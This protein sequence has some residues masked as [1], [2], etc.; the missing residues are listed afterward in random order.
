L[1][2]RSITGPW[3]RAYGYRFEAKDK[4]IVISG[5]TTY[6]ES[7]IDA[8]KGCDILVHEVYSQKGWERRTPDWQRYHAASHTSAPDLGRLAAKVRPKKL[9]LYH[10]LPMDETPDEILQ[11]IRA[12]FNGEVIYG[13]DLQVIR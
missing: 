1:P 5:D 9:V 6:S 2:F 3:K 11:E 7:L 4:V 8:A 10:Q 13:N 12:G